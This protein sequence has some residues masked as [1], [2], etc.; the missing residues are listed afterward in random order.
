MKKILFI[1]IDGLGDRPIGELKYKTP[2][3]SASTPNLD[4]LARNGIVGLLKPVFVDNFPTSKDGHLSLFGYDIKKYNIGRGVFEALGA[5]MKLKKGDVAL[6]GNF[7]TINEKLLIIDR[8]A[9]RIK[10]PKPLIKSLSS[11]KIKN[12]KFILKSTV[13]HRLALVLRGKNISDK[14]SDGDFHK[15]GIP[16]PSIKPKQKNY[17][18]KF[19]AKILNEFL[20]ISY[21]ILKNHPFNLKRERKGLLP[22]NYILLREA[23]KMRKIPSFWQMW[24]KRACFVVGGA[25][26]KGIARLLKMKEIKA[27]GAT[28]RKDTNLKEK[29]LA[30]KKSL[31]FYDFCY[32]H[33]KAVDNFSH[34]GD[35]VGKKLFIEKIDKNLKSLLSLKNTIIVIS[36]DHCTPCKLKEHSRDFVPFL[37]FGLGKN[38]VK[39]FSEKDC[40]FSKFGIIK[41]NQL[42]KFIFSLQ[43]SKI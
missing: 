20:K 21:Q 8:R 28:G 36:A 39:K 33:I 27:R 30:A 11:I 32:L 29:I 15:T 18:S 12:V 25:L 17:S 14:I 23:G 4:F 3:E 42:L 35:F 1:V 43:K 7:A 31:K 38:G 9:G 19:T 40:K 22:A 5:S 24:K 2:L 37:I 16:A 6:R 10:N 13:D 26:Y 34:D 41:Q